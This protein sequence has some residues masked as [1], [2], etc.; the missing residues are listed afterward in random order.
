MVTASRMPTTISFRAP[1]RC[2]HGSDDATLN[3]HRF[4]HAACMAV[5]IAC[6]VVTIRVLRGDDPLGRPCQN[7]RAACFKVTNRVLADDDLRAS[8]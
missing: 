6:M 5:K 2:V 1:G 8:W 4:H 7:R 3:A